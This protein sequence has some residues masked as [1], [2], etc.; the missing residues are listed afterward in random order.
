M[1][2]RAVRRAVLLLLVVG[3]A[4]WLSALTP[5]RAD[6][7]A[8]EGRAARAMELM[9]TQLGRALGAY[10]TGDA[11]TAYRLVREA[12]L[13]HFEELE[14][15]LRLVEP[16]FTLDM[17][18][19]FAALW[20]QIRARA[21]VPAVEEAARSVKD[22]LE[23]ADAMLEGTGLG[24]PMAAFTASFVIIFRE[25]LEAALLVAA[26]VTALATMRQRRY[27]RHL[28]GG[29]GLA[30]VATAVTWGVAQWIVTVSAWSRELISA[31]TSLL[32][33]A[34][35]FLV[36][37]WL[38]QRIEHRHW[39]E[40]V[41]GRV[42]GAMTSG[43]PLALVGVGFAAVYRE[44]FETVLFYTALGSMAGQS[45]AWVAGGF[46]AGALAITGLVAA[47]VW[48]GVRV[49]ARQLIGGATAITA[50][51]SVALLGHGVRELQETGLFPVT[52]LRWFPPVTF[53]L[54]QL[55]GVHATVETLL[56]QGLLLGVYGI[57]AVRLFRIGSRPMAG[58]APDHSRGR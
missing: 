21:P 44:G 46:L 48:L 33:V 29:A 10:R 8:V 11:E 12:Y 4:G 39:M 2:R 15:P 52:P 31:V 1:K 49:P 14:I 57:G 28:Y 22:G 23:R 5:A 6:N 18:L 50:L 24:V 37:F 17:E 51:L 54:A 13:D 58:L 30:I 9:R 42:W 36:S 7:G 47:M 26:L 55:T 38:V 45:R 56:A 43:R 27:A 32:A 53:T 41:R 40:Y 16:D 35:L 25:A 20:N 3:L 34:V 19:R